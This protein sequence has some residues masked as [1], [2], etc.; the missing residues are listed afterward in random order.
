MSKFDLVEKIRPIDLMDACKGNKRSLPFGIIRTKLGL[1]SNW[2]PSYFNWGR[3]ALFYLFKSLPYRSI[4]F[5]AF[6]CP[7][8]IEVAEQAGKEVILVEIDLD[9]F[10]IDVNKIPLETKCLV[11]VHTFGNPVDIRKIKSKFKKIFI[12]EDCAH[13]LFAKVNN[14]FVGSEG[15]AI[16]FSLY[17]Q[18]SN[19]NGCLLLT[20]EKI[21]QNQEQEGN[22]KYL[23]RLLIKLKGFHQYYLDFKRRQYLPIIEEQK[24]NSQ[25]PSDLTFLLFEKGFKKLEKEVEGRRKIVQFYYEQLKNLGFFKTQKPFLNSSPSYYQFTLRL[26]PELASV[27]DEIVFGLRKKNIIVDR[28]WYEAP[29]VQKKYELFQKKC[30]QALILAKTVINLPIYSFYTRADVDYLFSQVKQVIKEQTSQ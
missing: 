12:I 10:N 19:I 1:S 26:S 20:K 22:F 7:T 3:N 23:K 17:K 27:R 2:Q 5:P 8:L 13:A 24:I 14:N 11:V 18:V 9:T 16:L 4:T 29:I 21:A 15:D 6:T 28:L 30:P 25:K